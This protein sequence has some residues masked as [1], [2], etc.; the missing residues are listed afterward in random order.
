VGGKR[1]VWNEDNRV[2][3][4]LTIIDT[5]DSWTSTANAWESQNGSA[6]NR[7]QFV[8][9]AVGDVFE[10]ECWQL[11]FHSDANGYVGN[12][13]GVDVT[14][15]NSAQISSTYGTVSEHANTYA[16]Y[17]GVLAHGFHFLQWLQRSGTSG[18]TTFY[19]DAGQAA[20]QFGMTVR[21]LF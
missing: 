4:H 20:T 17:R 5:A 6:N 8:V 11:I 10:A 12:G 16:K 13:V 7:V 18:T 2:E 9:G 1:Y 3:R 15:A 19:G 21:G 14:N